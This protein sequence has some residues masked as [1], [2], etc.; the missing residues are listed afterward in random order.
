MKCFYVYTEDDACFDCGESRK[1]IVGYYKGELTE[2]KMKKIAR[3]IFKD[4][5]D[6]EFEKEVIVWKYDIIWKVD[7]YTKMDYQVE[8]FE[9]EDVDID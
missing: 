5:T 2:E 8:E 4:M 9:L 6:E 1:N 7:G 3:K